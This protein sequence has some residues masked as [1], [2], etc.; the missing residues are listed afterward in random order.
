MKSAIAASIYVVKIV[1]E[2]IREFNL[3]LQGEVIISVT[4][5]EETGG[6]AGAGYLVREGIIT[7]IDYTIMPEPTSLN[8]V[9]HAHK[10]CLWYKVSIKGKSAHA[11][12]PNLGI[13]AFEYMTQ[14]VSEFMKYKRVIEERVSILDSYPKGGNRASLVLGGMCGCCNAVN[15]VPS[16]AWFTIDRRV[17]PEES[18]DEVEKEIKSI[19][20]DFKRHHP[21]I[22]IE[23][24]DLLR[25]EPS[26]VGPN[27][28]LINLIKIS[29][30]KVL[31]I[32]VKP[33]LCPGFLNTRYFI[34]YGMPAVA[35]G[36]RRFRASSRT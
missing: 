3:R 31:G 32:E 5:D 1:E 2:V 17:L 12:L 33:V 22:D 13:N 36:P 34:K 10:G 9:W 19:V 35:W 20:N 24:K 26:H 29:T 25:I 8:Y 4:P 14:L 18:I 27:H 6:A 15:I 28:E 7:D 11:T 16:K 23:I 30:K 21:N